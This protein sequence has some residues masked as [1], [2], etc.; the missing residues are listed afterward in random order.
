MRSKDV[1]VTL[2]VR[3]ISENPR[4]MEP[5]FGEELEALKEIYVDIPSEE[6]TPIYRVAPWTHYH[7]VYIVHMVF[8]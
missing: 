8:I 4:T 5:L 7:M 1:V 3:S 6:V 2:R